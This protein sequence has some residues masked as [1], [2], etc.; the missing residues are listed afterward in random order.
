M[1]TEIQNFAKD[2][3]NKTSDKK[4]IL[5]ISHFDTDGITSASIFGMCLKSLDKNFYF[6]TGTAGRGNIANGA[7]WS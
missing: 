7:A 4:E 5:V 2:F 1:L 3:L 6:K